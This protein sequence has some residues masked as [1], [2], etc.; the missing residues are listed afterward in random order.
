MAQWPKTVTGAQSDPNYVSR[1][2]LD[3]V[4]VFH[5]IITPAYLLYRS[6]GRS[7]SIYTDTFRNA[8]DCRFERALE[9]QRWTRARSECLPGGGKHYS[10][11]TVMMMMMMVV[12]VVTMMHELCSAKVT[13]WQHSPPAAHAADH[14]T[15]PECSPAHTHVAPRRCCFIIH[16]G[17]RPYGAIQIC[18]LLLLFLIP[19]VVKIPGVKNYKS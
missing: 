13:T 14:A 3:C 19:Q 17:S 6:A 4:L 1:L 2:L 15:Q 16:G 18:L 5:K 12:V 11:A 9:V 7:L 10:Y 8:V